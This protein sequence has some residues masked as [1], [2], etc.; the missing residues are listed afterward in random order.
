MVVKAPPANAEDSTTAGQRVRA[1][2]EES[3]Q[4][5]VEQ[6]HEINKDNQ[7]SKEKK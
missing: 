7:V 5:L 2:I 4:D 1:F 3:R 6:R